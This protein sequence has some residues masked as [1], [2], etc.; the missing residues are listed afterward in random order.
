MRMSK[1][2]SKFNYHME[3]YKGNSNWKNY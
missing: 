1:I 3:V 2:L